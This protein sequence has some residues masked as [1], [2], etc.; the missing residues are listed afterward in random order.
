MTDLLTNLTFFPDGV[1]WRKELVPGLLLIVRAREIRRER[2]GVHGLVA[3]LFQDK[4]LA[5]DTFNLGRN[6][7]RQ[8]LAKSAHAAAGNLLEQA[9]PVGEMKHDLDI[10][11]LW[12]CHKWDEE[13]YPI[14]VFDPSEVTGPLGAVIQPYV[15]EEAGSILF[16]PP[17][18]G[19]TY[20]A[21]IMALC[22]QNSIQTFWKVSQRPVLYVNL[23]RPKASFAIREQQI[24]KALHIQGASGVSYLHARG[25]SLR[26]VSRSI[27][28]WCEANRNGVIIQDSISRAG[29]GKLNDDD[30]GTSFTD[31]MNSFERTWLGIG[32]TPRASDDHIFGSIMFDAGEDV[33]IKLTT[34]A[35]GESIGIGLQIVKN[36]HGP[37]TRMEV[38]A[39]DFSDQGLTGIRKAKSGEFVELLL[40]KKATRVEKLEAYVSE[41]GSTTATLAA[42]KT[43]IPRPDVSTMLKNDG[44][45]VAL[46]KQGKEQLYGLKSTEESTGQPF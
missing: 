37:K 40:T 11:C 33:G 41:V 7:E 39:L 18:S 6:E 32:H 30:T 10:L 22:I 35:Q 31:T 44:R 28:K 46:P 36:N 19:K 24:R 29:M 13:R 3:L 16:A 21:Q 34:D 20:M 14:G 12:L 4:V 38:L 17:G 42:E 45:F 23:E 2:T 43:G 15:L 9:Y 1:D 8:R 27:R 5:H 25:A 26:Q